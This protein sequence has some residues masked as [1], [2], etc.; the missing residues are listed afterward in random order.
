MKITLKQLIEAK[1]CKSDVEFFKSRFGESVEVTEELCLSVYDKFNWDWASVHF[2]TAPALDAYKKARAPALD[3][4]QKA[5]SPAWDAYKKA[6]APAWDSY[7]RVTATDLDAYKKATPPAWDA[8]KK[9]TPP[10]WDAYQ[11]AMASA[12]ARVFKIGRASCRER[13][14]TVV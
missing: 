5:M 8:Y 12:F 6:T 10:A 11:K 1:A 2:L 9:A 3:A 13:V 14:C 4:Y 7:E